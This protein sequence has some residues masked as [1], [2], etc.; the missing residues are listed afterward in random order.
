VPLAES[1]AAA[2]LAGLQR[3]RIL[4]SFI[5]LCYITSAY[6]QQKNFF[7]ASYHCLID[8]NFLGFFLFF[9]TF[10]YFFTLVAAQLLCLARLPA[11]LLR[12][13]FLRDLLLACF[14]C[15]G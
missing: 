6:M 2:V 3:N 12:W 15:C 14:S 7:H 8:G 5:F 13:R 10:P 4:V 11:G 9:I 1:G